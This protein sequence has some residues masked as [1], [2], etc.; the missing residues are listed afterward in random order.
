MGQV[1]IGVLLRVRAC[2]PYF[3][4]LLQRP[5]LVVIRTS[6][7]LMRL[8]LEDK[9]ETLK[10]CFDCVHNV[11]ESS[12]VCKNKVVLVGEILDSRSPDICDC[13]ACVINV[14]QFEL[15]SLI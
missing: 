12:R 5:K 10:I 2:R 9:F 3:A 13:I 11:E 7:R 1:R 14:L 4:E 8:V 6:T 15:F